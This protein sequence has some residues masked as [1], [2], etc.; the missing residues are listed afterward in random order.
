MRASYF[1]VSIVLSI[2]LSTH[3]TQPAFYPLIPGAFS[4]EAGEK[5]RKS[6]FLYV[7]GGKAAKNIQNNLIPRPVRRSSR[8]RLGAGL[9]V[10]GAF[11]V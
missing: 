10:G 9:E 4:P 2:V 1:V 8:R 3:V 11:R 7:F 5:G 6:T